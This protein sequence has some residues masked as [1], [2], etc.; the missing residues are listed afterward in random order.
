MQGIAFNVR[1]AFGV[2]RK[3]TGLQCCNWIDI[4]VLAI[5][6]VGALSVSLGS[7]HTSKQKKHFKPVKLKLSPA[8]A[9]HLVT[10]VTAQCKPCILCTFLDLSKY[11][12]SSPAHSPKI[13]TVA[14]E[15]VLVTC[16]LVW[17]L[18]IG[19]VAVAWICS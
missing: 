19:Q 18:F 5:F 9:I 6:T 16:C 15:T 4:T 12:H 10:S 8:A 17:F 14:Y 7:L 11:I 1:D 13:H 2:S 3:Q